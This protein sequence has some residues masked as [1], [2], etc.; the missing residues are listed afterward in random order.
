MQ[1]QMEAR[2][3]DFEPKPDT[4]LSR[5]PRLGKLLGHSF[6]VLLALAPS[7]VEGSTGSNG[8]ETLQQDQQ[9][10]AIL[11]HKNNFSYSVGGKEKVSYI[12]ARVKRIVVNGILKRFT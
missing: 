12:I 2:L 9:C 11:N 8:E 5:F 3:T 1:T 10:Q 7:L 6:M 4:K